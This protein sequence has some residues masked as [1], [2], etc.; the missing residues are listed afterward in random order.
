MMPLLFTVGVV[1][2][3]YPPAE[4]LLISDTLYIYVCGGVVGA[5]TQIQCRNDS[6][7]LGYVCMVRA[8]S[9]DVTLLVG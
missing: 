2:H 7:H 4:E 6:P 1:I 5:V 9:G 8:V 3:K